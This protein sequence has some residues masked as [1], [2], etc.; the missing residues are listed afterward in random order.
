MAR[1][2]GVTPRP[3]LLI[4]ISEDSPQLGDS[5]I[6]RKIFP[7]FK[8][9]VSTAPLPKKMRRRR[10]ESLTRPRYGGFA[11]AQLTV[12]DGGTFN[13]VEDGNE[14]VYDAKDVEVFGGEDQAQ[15][16]VGQGALELYALA[17]EFALSSV[18]MSTGTFGSGYNTAGAAAWDNASGKPL[19]DVAKAAHKISLRTGIRKSRLSVA[20]GG[21]TYLALTLNAQIQSQVR[22][23]LGQTN[24]Q[25]IVYDV[26]AETMARV[27]GVRQVLIGDASYDTAD[28]GQTAVMANV[29]PD[30]YCLVFYAPTPGEPDIFSPALGRTFVWEQDEASGGLGGVAQLPSAIEG[31]VLEH[32]QDG[33]RNTDVMRA[34]DW[35]HRMLLNKESAHLITGL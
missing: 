25:G 28:E 30:A 17:Q 16:H 26:P 12:T 13:C 14:E 21:G 31:M 24:D 23:I 5:F 33:T 2:A 1:I 18:L 22:A 7:V 35:S 4:S 29:W 9:Q 19:D 11:R 8:T 6:A 32:Y 34:R 3:D 20:M 15:M 27:L 10:V